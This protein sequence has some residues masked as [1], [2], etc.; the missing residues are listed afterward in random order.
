MSC[1]A[2]IR[3]ETI[4]FKPVRLPDR[5]Y[6]ARASSLDDNDDSGH[7]KDELGAGIFPLKQRSARAILERD[8]PAGY[9]G[10][11]TQCSTGN[12]ALIEADFLR[13]YE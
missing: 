11:W 13:Q 10:E 2:N 8:G 4:T 7:T 9:R 5:I 12:K 1:A 3:R 6:Q